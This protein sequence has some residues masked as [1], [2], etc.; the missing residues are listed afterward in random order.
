MTDI[1]QKPGDRPRHCR[2][3]KAKWLDSRTCQDDFHQAL[4]WDF[5]DPG[6]G[7][8]H[9]LTVLCYHLQHPNLYSPEGLR[10]AEGLLVEFL[11]QG[12]SPETVRRENSE[13]VQN[14]RRNWTV[15]GSG[16][17]KA[18]YRT[19]PT[20][21]MT[22]RDVVSGGLGNYPA[23]VRAWSESILKAL[24]ESENI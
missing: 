12:K 6:A 15:T 22:I 23:R 17:S 11:E 1:S 5:E 24:R 9:H 8:V 16:H 7:T 3:C 19:L 18:E 21:T 14:N 4:A 13:T 2:E 20:W 10:Y